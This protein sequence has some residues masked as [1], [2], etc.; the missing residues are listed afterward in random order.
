M[1]VMADASPAFSIR[2][3]LLLL[4]PVL[5]LAGIA[6]AYVVTLEPSAFPYK[7]K[8]RG[9]LRDGLVVPTK[10]S[11][12]LVDLDGNLVADP[13]PAADQIDPPTLVFA[14]LGSD[15]ER[16]KAEYADLVK[17]LEKET[18]KKVELIAV[19]DTRPTDLRD[20]T[21]H[22]ANL[23]TGSV[24]TAV[25]VGGAVPFC[26]MADE[27]GKFSYNMEIVVPV[28]SPI[29]SPKQLKGTDVYFV[30]V[31]SLSGFKAPVVTLYEKFQLLP[32]RDYEPY[33]QGSQEMLAQG[34]ASGRLKAAPVASDLLKRLIAQGRVDGKAIRSIYTSP[35]S[36]PPACYAYS[37]RLKPELAKKLTDA[38]FSFSWEGSTLQKAYSPAGQTKFVR[39]S[40]K[41][42]WAPVRKMES[43]A[44]EL[45]QKLADDEKK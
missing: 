28:K 18:G 34:V 5:L 35:E 42:D 7:T 26:V 12:G 32:G 14:V 1:I 41:D 2:R 24:S 16:E 40:Y 30:S 45:V 25:N 9:Y 27:A 44:L 6:A 23:A 22:L 10:L 29:T 21:V 37:Y 4:A 3:V 13:A 11:E 39:I 15:L 20:G 31:Y 33:L 8:L 38:F 19:D 43:S 36:F 17:H